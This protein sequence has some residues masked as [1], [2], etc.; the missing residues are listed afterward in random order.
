LVVGRLMLAPSATIAS[1]SLRRCPTD[2][3]PIS[4]RSAAV[5]SGSVSASM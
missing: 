5:N 2:A 4:C 3:T 1:I